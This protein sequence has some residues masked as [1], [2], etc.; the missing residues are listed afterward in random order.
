MEHVHAAELALEHHPLEAAQ[1][2]EGA[3]TTALHPL[4]R[5]G[6]MEVGIW[7][8]AVGVST[9]VEA[10]ETF[11]VLHG[12]ARIA[13]DGGATIEVGPGDVVRLDAGAATT[14]T[15]TEALRK[16]YLVDTV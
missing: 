12:R 7:E 16:V 8:H 9:D 5:H 10:A 11:V 15:V 1:I 3:P 14:W 2:V 4:W 13:V 6:A